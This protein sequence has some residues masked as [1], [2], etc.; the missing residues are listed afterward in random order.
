MIY[1]FDL[2]D[3]LKYEIRPL[4]GDFKAKTP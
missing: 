3:L 1:Q 4:L 2:V